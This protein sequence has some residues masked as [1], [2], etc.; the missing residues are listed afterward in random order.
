MKKTI[1]LICYLFLATFIMAQATEEPVQENG[2]HLH[3]GLEGHSCGTLP[4][5]DDERRYTLDV[6]DKA[7]DNRNAGTT[8]LP[9]R[10]HIV[11]KTDGSGG[12]SEGDI[13]IG[14]S[15]LNAFYLDAGI[16]FY[17]CTINTINSDTYYTFHESEEAAMTAAYSTYDA[18]NI[19]FVNDITTSSGS[20]CGYARYPSNST[21]TMNILMDNGCTTTYENGTLV[22]ELGHFFNL[23]HTHDGTEDGN[24]DPDAENV[25]RTGP[26]ANCTTTGDML[27][28]TEADPNGSNDSGCNFI[29]D[30]M[31]TQ[32]IHSVTY[33]PDLSNIMSYYS[34]YCGGDFTV[35]QYTR[36]ANALTTRLGHSAYTLNGCAA[37]AVTDASGLTATANNSYGVD[38]SWTD[39]AS[40]E[41]GY[42][43]E[44]STDG[45]TTWF[46]IS[47]GGVGP[48]VTSYTDDDLVANTVHY[49]RVKASNDDAN[50]YSATA[51]VSVGLIQCVTTHQSNSCT[52]GGGGAFG[53]AIYNFEL[54]NGGTNL[55]SNPNNGCNGALSIFTG[56]HVGAVT[57]GSTYSLDINFQ[58]T[59]GSSYYSQWVTVWIDKNQDGDFEDSGEM[60]YQSTSSD[61]PTVTPSITIP[62]NSLNG[63]T[64]LRVRTGSNSMGQVTDPCDYIALGET[65]DYGLT[66]SGGLPVELV[67]FDGRKMEDEIKLSWTTASEENN[68]YFIIE[69][70][71]NG[72]DF[73][74]LDRVEGRGTT[75][76][77]QSY[78][79][80]DAQPLNGNN[81][82]R[83]IQVDED[84]T[85]HYE[86]KIVVV[87]YLKQSTV[88]VNPNPIQNNL[89][90]IDF[91]TEAR[92][93][94]LVEV[95]DLRGDLIL[96][97]ELDV[98]KGLNH[99]ELTL[100]TLVNGI[101]LLKTT[102]GAD[103]GLIRFVK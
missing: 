21:V 30:G 4:M 57:A 85:M 103:V 46:P 7:G 97:T 83:M 89:L 44:R 78:E 87:E 2:E 28:D 81:Y 73:E 70:S 18:V 59:T 53:V 71:N 14:I 33:A 93:D 6:V 75:V 43:V 76:D 60:I 19:Y 32:D 82:Y 13:N 86:D 100:P 41:T 40:N 68:D 8:L 62:A 47:G 16:E 80:M 35:E 90:A 84:G 12:I 29:N 25:A 10:I 55:I 56:T 101:Y 98:D 15:Y 54:N 58:Y 88:S 20:P 50:D 31:S 39:N 23:Q 94:V 11:T 96:R 36:I 24:T 27:C 74:Y 51:N 65:E 79:L 37:T 22:H 64:T 17:I 99:F 52:L 66:V 5:T 91:K 34:D 45:G 9:V 38:L 3:S 95:Y 63:S 1:L 42:L 67:S 69:K 92:A 26:N 48:D 49:Y 77:F 72:I 102:Q 61:G